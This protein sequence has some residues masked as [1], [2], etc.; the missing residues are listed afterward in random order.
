MALTVTLRRDEGFTAAEVETAV[1]NALERDLKQAQVRRDLFARECSEFEQQHGMSSD[2]FLKAF[3]AGQLGDDEYL[4]AW[5]AA[6]MGLDG[7]D[8]RVQILEGLSVDRS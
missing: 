6:K 7:W 2:A 4:F 8:R 3:E 1:V 5:Y